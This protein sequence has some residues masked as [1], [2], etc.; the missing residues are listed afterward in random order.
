MSKRPG[1]LF[2][3]RSIRFETRIK[4]NSEA[5][6]VT[7]T[8]LPASGFFS[9]ACLVHTG[10]GTNFEFTSGP[11]MLGVLKDWLPVFVRG[12]KLRE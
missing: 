10:S 11:Q 1:T 12:E 2:S 5:R 6:P 9:G 8:T 4:S 7:D 3:T